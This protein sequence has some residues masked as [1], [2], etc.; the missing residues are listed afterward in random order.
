VRIIK[1][2]LDEAKTE[3]EAVAAAIA[4]AESKGFREFGAARR[5]PR[6]IRSTATTGASL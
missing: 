6:A 3:R 4:L 2:F 5:L 1:R